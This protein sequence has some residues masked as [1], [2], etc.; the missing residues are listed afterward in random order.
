[1]MT[2]F[3]RTVRENGNRGTDHGTGSVMLLLGGGVRGGRVHGGWRGL[4][5]P[6]LFEDRDL[7][8]GTDVRSVLAEA[9]AATL[10]PPDLGR[11]FPGFTPSRVGAFD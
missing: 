6:G 1:V 9:L 7:A 2:E 3:G 5:G 4:D 8:I 11:V 10:R